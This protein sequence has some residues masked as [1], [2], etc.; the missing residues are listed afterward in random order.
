MRRVETATAVPGAEVWLSVH[1]EIRHMPRV[2]AVL[3]CV[4][5]AFHRSAGTAARAAAG[6]IRE[7]E[8]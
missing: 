6:P 8:D 4:A 3:E 5:D 1:Q 2:R 7:L